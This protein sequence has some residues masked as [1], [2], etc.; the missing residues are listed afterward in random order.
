MNPG[1]LT[2]TH[3]ISFK[4]FILRFLICDITSSCPLLTL[5]FYE[6]KGVTSYSPPVSHSTHVKF[7]PHGSVQ[8]ARHITVSQ[9]GIVIA[10]MELPVENDFLEFTIRTLFF[11]F[12][13]QISSS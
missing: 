10:F 7:L 9:T 5:K 13:N 6:F 11:D 2:T 12:Q 8:N 4:S 3:I 1:S